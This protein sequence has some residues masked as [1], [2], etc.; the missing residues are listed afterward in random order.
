MT[1]TEVVLNSEQALVA[2]AA[3]S[4]RYVVLAPPG[5]GKTEV[6]SAR[7]TNLL[8]QGVD[9]DG[10]LVV[11][12]S[13]AAV[14][15][16]R[17]RQ[18]RAGSGR[19]VWV[20]TLD[21]LAT[22]LL[23]DAGLDPSGLGF[24]ARID[25]LNA[26]VSTGRSAVLPALNHLIVDEFQDIVGPRLQLVE[27]LLRSLEAEAGF[28]VLGDEAQAIYDF[29]QSR[30][31][32]S[33]PRSGR[34]LEACDDLGASE[35]HLNGQYRAACRDARVA[36]SLTPLDIN[37]AA[38][39]SRTS[40]FL[41][42]L[43]AMEGIDQV[44]RE[45]TKAADRGETAAVLALSNAEALDVNSRLQAADLAV[46]L[47]PPSDQR[48]LAPWIALTLAGS[49]PSVSKEAFEEAWAEEELDGDAG[50]AWRALRRTTSSQSRL[51][52]VPE[53]ASR[54]AARYVPAMLES[55]PPALCTSTVHRAKGLEFDV[56]V[57]VDP[58]SWRE[59]SSAESITEVQRVLYVAI[60]RGR[61]LL[62]TLNAGPRRWFR[63]DLS[64]RIIR[65]K[66]RGITGFELRP[67]DLGAIS[68]PG[69]SDDARQTIAEFLAGWRGHPRA[70][71]WAM[72]PR[73][74]TLEYP[75]YD[76]LLDDM[77]IGTTTVEF[78]TALARRTGR[79]DRWVPLEGGHMFGT[80]TIAGPQQSGAI[81]KHGLWLAPLVGGALTLRWDK[82]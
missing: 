66:N 65:L 73:K 16:I 4:A 6:V 68:A 74:S 43:P 24:D 30:T 21:S 63:D 14:Y 5:S 60:T 20:S 69:A 82:V 22:R 23:M 67:S 61:S 40:D 71:S 25:L 11:S 53:L 1:V 55:P 57:L 9:F 81:G 12:F 50:A 76:C 56:V 59:R 75:V 33:A 31:G 18:R 47:V 27:T 15:A 35:I 38:W 79:L 42:D 46:T 3:V 62:M 37:E 26:E 41:R 32:S 80:Q 51:L 39:W 17:E 78:G 45:L 28:T 7:V 10:L 13:R 72:N 77:C 58:E 70:V 36:A 48:P 2:S 49:Q 34:L 29:Q 19:W 54:L 8:D 52:S 44:E 64:E